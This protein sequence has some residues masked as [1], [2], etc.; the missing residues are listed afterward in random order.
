M[1]ARNSQ[2]LR[3][4]TY[5]L[6]ALAATFAAMGSWAQDDSS[7]I[8][9]PPKPPAME[10]EGSKP[11]TRVR[12][13]RDEE[14]VLTIKTQGE[15]GERSE[16]QVDLG[17][18]FGGPLSQRIIEKLERKGILDER[19]QVAEEAL[20]S[21]PDNV[22]IGLSKKYGSSHEGWEES[23]SDSGFHQVVTLPIL[24]LL[25]VFGMPVLIVWLVT[26]NSYRKK[27][28]VMENINNMVADGRDVPPEMLDM[29]EDSSPKNTGDRGITLIAV[30]AAV[31]IWLTS[32]AGFGVGSLGLIPLFI[33]LARFINWKLDTKQA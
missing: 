7:T 5:W 11:D 12:I 25:C 9:N 17:A 28:L 23:Q 2:P 26:R 15:D 32:L 4:A 31:F 19:G 21:V 8:P 10:S 27:Q 18:E 20:D 13:M 16:V 30:G 33:G 24:A 1:R 29:L 14:G 3:V 22:Q 6:A